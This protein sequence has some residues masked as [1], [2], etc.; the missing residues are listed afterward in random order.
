MHLRSQLGLESLRK[1]TSGPNWGWRGFANA[2]QVTIGADV[3]SRMH[4][5]SQLGLA[6]LRECTSSHDWNWRGFANAPQVTIETGV[7]SRMHLRSC[8]FANA[9]QVTIGAGVASQMHLRSQL[10]LAWLREW[11]EQAMRTHSRTRGKL[12]ST[13]AGLLLVQILLKRNSTKSP[14]IGHRSEMALAS[15]CQSSA[16]SKLEVQTSSH[17]AFREAR[18]ANE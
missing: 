13:S 8:G 15:T 7:A 4:L 14:G 18:N 12:K 1:C 11:H 3:T 17:G 6:W 5:R 16:N 2:P 9:P 10:G